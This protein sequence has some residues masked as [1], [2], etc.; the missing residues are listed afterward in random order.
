MTGGADVWQVGANFEE[1]MK[2]YEHVGRRFG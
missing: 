1:L 2:S